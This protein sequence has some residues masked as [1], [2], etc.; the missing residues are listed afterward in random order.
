MSD[1]ISVAGSALGVVSV[2]IQVCQG[3]LSYY[4][5]WRSY[6]SQIS[7]FYNTIEGLN[8]TLENLQLSLEKLGFTNTRAA[9]N[10]FRSIV[11]CEDGVKAL[12]TTLEKFSSIKAPQ[13]LREKF[14]SY[15]LQTLFPFK[16]G[17]LQSM[18]AVVMDLQ[19]NLNSA[20]QVLEMSVNHP[21]TST[22]C[23]KLIYSDSETS[24]LA[25]A[26]R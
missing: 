18:K 24:S 7:H 6:N 1:P 3:L 12:K 8:A 16:Q 5:A 20:L 26:R 10:V 22:S 17:T 14:H 11:S 13:G 19:I 23:A 21:S 4:N 9:Q 2:G 15:S 25:K